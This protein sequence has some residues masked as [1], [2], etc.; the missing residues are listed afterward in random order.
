MKLSTDPR[1]YAY[2]AQGS[3]EPVKGMNDAEWF[4]EMVQGLAAVGF[5]DTDKRAMFEVGA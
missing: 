2:L 3:V 4:R 1:A 5:R